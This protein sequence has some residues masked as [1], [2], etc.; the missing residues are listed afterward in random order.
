MRI[1]LLSHRYP[2]STLSAANLA[3]ELAEALA[4]RGHE[5]SVVTKM[6]REYL[7]SDYGVDRRLPSREVLRGVRVVRVRGM[8]SL[9]QRVVARAVEHLV[10]A[11]GFARALSE[12]PRP[13]VLLV[14]SPPVPV[15]LV[16]IGYRRFRGVPFV[17]QLWDLY[18]RTAIDLGKLRSRA[19]IKLM[20]W[21]E[22]LIYRHAAHIVV[23]AAGSLRY[24]VHD[25]AL[26]V[27]RV[28]YVPTWADMSR[29]VTD[30]RENGFRIQHGLCGRF[31]V[32]Y[33]G[34]LGLAQDFSPVIA[35]AK[36]L[37][38][39]PELVFVIIGNGVLAPKWKAMAAGLPNMRFLT[40]MSRAQY[41]EALLASDA[42]LVVLS[43]ALNTPVVPGKMQSIMAAARPVLALVPPA[44]E[45]A[46]LVASSK[47][48]FVV[49]PG[50]DEGFRACIEK[51]M[52]DPAMGRD[53]GENG[54][55]YAVQ[56][57]SLEQAVGAFERVLTVAARNGS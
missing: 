55:L 30:E 12:L 28:H 29:P 4:A 19:L 5:V 56:H 43:G 48:G 15:P 21:I 51:L 9:R 39:R 52:V 44:G 46:H 17:L 20:G 33:G 41:E 40:P 57:F 8:S 53:M 7:P 31:V 2:P 24:L 26:P 18:P 42:C 47:C 35:C 34:L 11:A 6:P 36:S 1:T 37:R 3:G 38:H 49:G 32:S 25:R 10:L 13:D 54:R 45:A 16:A 14:F 22:S 50:D 27:S 23:P